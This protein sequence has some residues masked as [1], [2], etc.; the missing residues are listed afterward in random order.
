M[1]EWFAN[2]LRQYPEIAIFVSLAFGYYFGSFTYKGLG[3]G[4]V[5][6]TLIAAV[7]IGQLGIEVTGPLKPF[8]FL[9]F[10]FAIGYAVG[11]QFVRGIAKD[12]LPQAVFAAVVC[13]LCLLSAYLAAVLAGYDIGS[14]AGLYAGSQTISASMGL[15]TDAINRLGLTPDENRALLDAMPVAYAVTYIFGTIGSAVIIA[16]LGPALLRIDLEEACRRYEEKHA[17]KKVAGGPG[18]AWHQFELRAYRVREGA[19]IVG[20]TVI[21]AERLLPEHRVYLQRVRRGDEVAEATS[22]TVIQS[23]DVV[24]IAGRRDVLVNLI[25]STAEE[26]DDREL[27]AVQTE[28]LDVYVTSKGVDGKTLA[29][30]SQMPWARGV[31]LRK[32]TRGATATDIPIL[33]DTEINRG[34]ILTLAGRAQDVAQ[35]TKVLGYPDKVTDVAD[36]MFIGAAIAIGALVGALVY[37]VGGVPL[38][39]STSGGALIAGIFFGW[40][41]SVRPKFGRIPSPTVWFMNSVGLNVFIAIV[42]LSAGPKFVA[43]LQQLGFGL[44]LWGIFATTLPL[45][46]SMYV[47]KYLFRFDDAI[48]LGAVSGARTTTASLGMVTDRANSQIPGLGYTVTYAVGNTLLTIWGMVLVILLS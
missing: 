7:I 16:L 32:I 30:L 18:T 34:D 39:L 13:V 45:V 21:E 19:R 37:N 2:T 22:D 41:R 9:M 27:L 4:A 42:G 1:F 20:K 46:L 24:A 11:P 28:G 35:A 31:F 5:T 14:A 33:P 10:L 15:A 38:T 23:G 48:V 6:A 25:G 36:V 43:G 12:G 3:L 8:F 26:V 17:G 29:E 44:F 40:L 47:G